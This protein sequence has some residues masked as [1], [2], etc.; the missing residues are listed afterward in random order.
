MAFQKPEPAPKPPVIRETPKDT[1]VMA[2]KS[3]NIKV[4]DELDLEQSEVMNA[5]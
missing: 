2:F 1:Y 5:F 4:A 3:L